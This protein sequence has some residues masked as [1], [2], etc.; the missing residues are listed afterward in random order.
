MC[1]SWAGRVIRLD[2]EGTAIVEIDGRLVR[3]A[4]V[5][6]PETRA[7]EWVV[8]ATGLVLRRISRRQARRLTALPRTAA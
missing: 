1:V 7:G 3:A 4:T 5:A 2:E 8:V 6:C